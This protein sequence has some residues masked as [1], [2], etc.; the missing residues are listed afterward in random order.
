MQGARKVIKGDSGHENVIA[1]VNSLAS[2]PRK[3][4]VTNRSVKPNS[5][6]NVNIGVTGEWLEFTWITTTPKW[7]STSSGEGTMEG[8]AG[9]DMARELSA[10][11]WV[12][13]EN[14]EK[15]LIPF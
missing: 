15:E 8:T 9:M 1:E 13:C 11:S 7:L 5:L 6:H 4:P 14:P 2:L 10:D 3:A 12:N